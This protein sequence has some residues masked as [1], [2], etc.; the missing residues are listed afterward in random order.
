MTV[1]VGCGDEVD[2]ATALIE[3]QVVPSTVPSKVIVPTQVPVIEAEPADFHHITRTTVCVA[4]ASVPV[5]VL[6]ASLAIDTGSA[7]ALI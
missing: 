5:E 4:A 3:F 1:V 6:S 7:V 2:A